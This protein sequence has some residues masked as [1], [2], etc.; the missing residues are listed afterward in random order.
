MIEIRAATAALKRF[1]RP[2]HDSSADDL[3]GSAN[4]EPLLR[5]LP[6]QKLTDDAT[7]RDSFCQK[8]ITFHWFQLFSHQIGRPAAVRHLRTESCSS[9]HPKVSGA[10][11]MDDAL[12]S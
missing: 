1:N 5:F 11:L 9:A 2:H 8:E 10:S 6:H 4:H 7:G 12:D 3:R